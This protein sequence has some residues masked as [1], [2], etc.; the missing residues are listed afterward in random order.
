M[1]EN[2]ILNRAASTLI[3]YGGE[4]SSFVAD[5]AHGSFIYDKDDRPLIDFT[6]CQM[7]SIL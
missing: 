6:S 1:L 2:E 4:F 5:H 3:R 7:S